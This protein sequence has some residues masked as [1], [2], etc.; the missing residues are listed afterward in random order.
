M[1]TLSRPVW[2][3][4]CALAL[5]TLSACGGSSDPLPASGQ[6]AVTATPD[7]TV[8][9]VAGN[10]LNVQSSAKAFFSALPEHRWEARQLNGAPAAGM[11]TFSD[12]DCRG[13]VA[14]PGFAATASVPGRNATSECASVL[15]VAL[16]TPASE[17]EI[18]SSARTSNGSASDRFVLKVTP[19]AQANSGFTLAVPVLPLSAQINETVRIPASVTFNEGIVTDEPVVYEWVQRNGPAVAMAARNTATM[20]FVPREGGDYVFEVKASAKVRGKSET[21]EGAVVVLV[22]NAVVNLGVTAGALQAVEVNKP[23]TLRG[24][25]SG[26]NNYSVRWSRVSGPAEVTIFNGDT[27]TAQF[28]PTEAGD[29]VF[30]MQAV[31]LGKPAVAKT[32]QTRVSAYVPDPAVPF[33]VVNAGAAQVA[34]RNKPVQ[35]SATVQAGVPAPSN[36]SYS[37]VQVSGPSVSLSG[38]ASLQASFVPVQVGTYEFEFKATTANTPAVAKSDRTSVQVMGSPEPNFVISA[39]GIQTAQASIAVPLTGTLS[40]VGLNAVNVSWSQVSGPAVSLFNASTLQAQFLPTLAGDY[41][42]ELRAVSKTDATN[43]RTAKTLVAVSA[44]SDVP[45]FAISAGDAQVVE[46]ATAV[47]LQSTVVQGAVKSTDIAYQWT[48]LSGPAV[49]LANA[50]AERASFVGAEPGLYTFQLA[51][52]VGA[53]TKTTV[54]SVQVLAVAPAP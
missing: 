1:T 17:W 33:F 28:T 35:L 2:G 23:A 13:A 24:A 26:S 10:T 31:H 54:T 51:V 4:T 38:S 9:L 40:G 22:D 44:T 50:Q 47:A 30:E 34:E 12:P 32:A 19:S 29:Y 45:V 25:V 41:E 7:G 52:T 27:L 20:A 6:V 53:V 16:E 39:G 5:A 49:T 42:F 21:R 36:L 48:Q 8:T 14:V 18:T 37:W 46:I 15:R 43:V 11:V 3:F